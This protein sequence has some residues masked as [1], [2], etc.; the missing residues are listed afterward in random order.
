MTIQIDREEGLYYRQTLFDK[1][2]RVVIKVGSAILTTEHGMNHEVI[3]NLAR[4]IVFL[5][6]SGREVILVTSGAVAAGRKKIAF[7]PNGELAMREKQALAAI[8]Q[9]VLMHIYDE[10]FARHGK[11]IAQILLTHSDLSRRDR[12]LNVRNT[13]NTLFQ[14]GVI[15]IINE[16]DTVSVEE[17]RFGDN[18]TLGALVANLI[19]ADMFICLTDVVGLYNGNPHA[20]PEAQPIYTVA[21]V[22]PEIE[23][24]A[25]NVKSA[26]GTGGMQSKI[27]A[28]KMVA[29]GGGSSFI[30]PGRVKNILQQLFSGEMI[31]TF[32]L[33]KT[34][35][36]PSRKHWIGYVLKPKGRLVLDAGACLA[37][38]R[39]GKSLLPSG[40]LEVHG[41]FG[42]GDSVECCDQDGRVIAVGLINYGSAEVEQIRGRKTGEIA[43]I[44]GYKDSDEVMHRD[45]LVLR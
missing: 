33:P 41:P 29:A 38:T 11:N 2:K 28:A 13:L 15:P 45:N 43:A 36:L 27:R 23:A 7:T 44:L 39:K 5:H 30:G 1:A 34:S 20:N 24:M 22:T 40:I 10:T 42:L 14:F 19:E 37:L 6:N 16:N 25:G 32:F 17:L 18:D 31:G 21:E 26:L 8:G 35:K 12:Y 4:E 3:D 9:S